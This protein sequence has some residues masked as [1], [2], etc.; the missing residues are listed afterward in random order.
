MR[1]P[2]TA[3]YLKDCGGPVVKSFGDPAAIISRIFPFTREKTNGKVALVRHF[4]HERVPLKLPESFDEINVLMS[5]PQEIQDFISKLVSYDEVVTSA[6]HV[7]IVCHAYGIPCSLVSFEGLEHA[8]HG[9]GIKYSDYTFGVGL[10][11]I[12]PVVI[13]RDLTRV[14]FSDIRKIL[15]ISEDKKDEIESVIKESLNFF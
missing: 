13:S 12:S 3:D 6:M 14:P 2:I 9:S 8:V 15:S 10:P 1:G 4:S 7:M 5:S 11:E